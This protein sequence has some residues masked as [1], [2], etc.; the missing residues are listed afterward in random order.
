MRVC[1]FLLVIIIF[2][3]D[4]SK[5]KVVIKPCTNTF[6]NIVPLKLYKTV[7]PY[8]LKYDFNTKFV[9]LTVDASPWFKKTRKN[10]PTL[11]PVIVAWL[12]QNLSNAIVTHLQSHNVLLD[13]S[14]NVCQFKKIRNN[15]MAKGLIDEIQNNVEFKLECPFKNGRYVVKSSSFRQVYFPSFMKIRDPFETQISVRSKIG[16][17]FENMFSIAHKW[18]VIELNDGN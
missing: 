12:F 5:Q 9:N 14:L 10:P 16:I 2:I 15:L 1:L 7:Y 6:I 18:E 17:R 11:S 8:E 4:E 13:Q 3:V